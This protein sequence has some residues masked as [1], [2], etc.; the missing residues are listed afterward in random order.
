MQCNQPTALF[1]LQAR[2]IV[3][4]LA[5]RSPLPPCEERFAWLEAEKARQRGLGRKPRDFFYMV[6]HA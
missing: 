2:W 3:Q 1:D 4:Q 6:K 5:G